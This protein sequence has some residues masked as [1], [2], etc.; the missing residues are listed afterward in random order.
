VLKAK[1]VIG[2][3]ILTLDTGSKLDKVKDVVID[4]QGR[5]V[6]ALV[7][8]EGGF[9]SDSRVVPI[10]EI[11]SFGKDAVVIQSDASVVRVNDR[12]EL[13]D[14][15][16]SDETILGKKVYTTEGEDQGS[17]NDVYFDEQS[18]AVVGY[19]ISGG[20]LGD[21]SKGT[22]Y[23]ATD[24]ITNV[25][26]D[27][28]YVH[29]ETAEILESQVGGLQGQLQSAGEKLGNA[30]SAVTG[31]AGDAASRGSE[32]GA[33]SGEQALVGKRT[34]S[35]V[36]TDDGSVLI[37]Q[38]RRVRSDD[39]SQAKAAGKLQ[40]L[41]ASVAM[42]E[43]QQAGAGVKDGLGAAG[44]TAASLWDKF[45]AKVGEV[46]DASGKRLD[47]EQTKRRLASISD[48]VGR[49]VT[50]VILDREDN[51]VLNL[52]DIITHQA[53]QRAYDAGGL[54]SLLESAYKG[55]VEFTKDEMRAPA[56]VEAEATV[57]KSS[58]GATVVDE[59]ETKVDAAEQERQ[60]EK[61]RKA[62]E[63]ETKRQ[64]RE[65]ERVERE[66]ERKTAKAEREADE[67]APVQDP[68]PAPG[69]SGRSNG[70]GAPR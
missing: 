29:P 15:V 51:V 10:D 66:Q 34:G 60:A 12:Q 9:M 39:V 8:D 3:N 28:I 14:Y 37:P 65:S 38:G 27:V 50:K 57:D 70:G 56:A 35:D 41:T 7:V 6:V 33:A 16:D 19:E 69:S 20:M 64:Q 43:A 2:K 36:T 46:T 31:A 21:V 53:I 49:P 42:G 47:E 54:D 13:R 62:A 40:D 32:A 55:T 61:E 11:A 23:L 30:G 44:D 17:I 58:G 26:S 45:T 18:G 67:P 59:L 63:S 5:A 68:S 1:S 4:P 25:G 24:E 52:G 48:A 22:S